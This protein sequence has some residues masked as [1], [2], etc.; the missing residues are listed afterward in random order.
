M[1]KDLL[2]TLIESVF[3]NKKEW[4][5]KQ[6]LPKSGSAIAIDPPPPTNWDLFYTA[7][8][9]GRVWFYASD[10]SGLNI[11]NQQT[12]EMQY[13]SDIADGSLYTIALSIRCKKGDKVNLYYRKES[14][15]SDLRCFF[16]PDDQ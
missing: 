4:I 5:A 12:G 14:V 3:T 7:P 10:C 2:R 16:I 1:L 11:S 9:N 15:S 13:V 8:G 6:T